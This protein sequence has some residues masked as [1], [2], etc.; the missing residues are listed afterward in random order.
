MDKFT[1]RWF[2]FPS[3]KS[4]VSS[5]EFWSRKEFLDA[6]ANWNRVGAIWGGWKYVEIE[7]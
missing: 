1:Y 7:K 3:R 5:R 2:H 4:G 6:L